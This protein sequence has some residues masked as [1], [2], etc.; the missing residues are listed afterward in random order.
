MY[1]DVKKLRFNP[2][3]KKLG[4]PTENLL[5]TSHAAFTMLKA[6]NA[7]MRANYLKPDEKNYDIDPTTRYKN[8]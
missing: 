5:K 1:I 2:Y 8:L 4:V 6:V 7:K 3:T